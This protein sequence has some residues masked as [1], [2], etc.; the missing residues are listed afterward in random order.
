MYRLANKYLMTI[1]TG[2]IFRIFYGKGKNIDRLFI[3]M[4]VINIAN[5]LY[6]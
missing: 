3:I 5:D 1:I 6:L 2:V 4:Y